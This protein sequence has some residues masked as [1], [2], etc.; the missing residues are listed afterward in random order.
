M[1]QDALGMG[2]DGGSCLVAMVGTTGKSRRPTCSGRVQKSR[3][4]PIAEV[5]PTRS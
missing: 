5:R 3:P 2:P 1:S 4:Y